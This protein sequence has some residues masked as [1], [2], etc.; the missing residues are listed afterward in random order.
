[1]L[2]CPLCNAHFDSGTKRCPSDG[3]RPLEASVI[4][5]AQG[6]PL[7]GATIAERY[8]I[9]GRVGSGGMG[10][11][12]RAEQ[13]GMGREVALKVLRKDLGRDPD[14]AARFHREARTLSQLKHPNTV[15]V[16]DFGQTSDR[17][18]YLAMELLEGE[19]LSTRIKR[20][21]PLDVQLTIRTAVGVLRSLD[22]AHARGIVHRDLKP[23]NIFLAKVHGVQPEDGE[24]VKVVDFG[25]AKIR[26]GERGIDAL[27]TQE[28]T[29]FGTPRYMSPEQA[30]GKP[31]DGRSD[32]YAVGV[33]LFHMLTGRPPFTD[34][35]AVIVM[36]HHIKTV[37]PPVRQVAPN[38]PIP[39]S[40]EKLVQRVLAKDPAK[41]PQT[42]A[43][44]LALLDIAANDARLLADGGVVVTTG[45]NKTPNRQRY[46]AA[47]LVGVAIVS[48]LIGVATLRPPPRQ[49]TTTRAVNGAQVASTPLREAPTRGSPESVVR[50]AAASL[51]GSEPANPVADDGAAA[52]TSDAAV[53]A[54]SE[55]DAAV[56]PDIEVEPPVATTHRGH[57]RIR[58][59]AH[60]TTQHT[61]STRQTNPANPV[62]RWND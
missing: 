50:A 7:L 11:V 47:G 1:M 27:Q 56:D 42:A 3:R 43:E 21:G 2:V 58:H 45:P 41:R 18:L 31:I 10:T 51:S 59:R 39:E 53:V 44:F 29:V 37:P 52:V 40:L 49:T 36:A 61:T 62:S 34:D 24:S 16:F 23:D 57:R 12:Y 33:L 60:S 19:M 17:L 28:G 4:E 8:V 20:E 54:A 5:A 26:D 48:T 9:V 46:L 55:A 25:I 13:Q 35:D 14:T 6:D 15:T 22:E 38:R 32:L 30:Q